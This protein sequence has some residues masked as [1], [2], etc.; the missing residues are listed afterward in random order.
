MQ[1][2]LWVAHAPCTREPLFLVARV[3]VTKRAVLALGPCPRI[4]TLLWLPGPRLPLLLTV[5]WEPPFCFFT[6]LCPSGKML[7]MSLLTCLVSAA[8]V[9]SNL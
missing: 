9:D 2:G 1:E 7:L 4:Q 8:P 3:A 5:P 6:A